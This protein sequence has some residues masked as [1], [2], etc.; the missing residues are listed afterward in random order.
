MYNS[1]HLFVNI[2]VMSF[3]MLETSIKCPCLRL[4]RSKYLMQK[5]TY[6]NNTKKAFV[7]P[8]DPKIQALKKKIIYS[9]YLES[10]RLRLGYIRNI[11]IKNTIKFKER[12]KLINEL[13]KPVRSIFVDQFCNDLKSKPPDEENTNLEENLMID[14][15]YSIVDK[16]NTVDL[17]D[18][19]EEKVAEEAVLLNTD[20]KDLYEKYL[21]AKDSGIAKN[22][23]FSKFTDSHESCLQ[24]RDD[25]ICNRN[26]STDISGIPYNW[27]VDYEQFN[28]EVLYEIKDIFGSAVSDSKISSVPCGGC[29]AKLHCKDKAL[30]GFLASEIFVDKT[31]TQL[32][33]MLC[34][35]CHFIKFYNTALDVK[36]S[37][38]DYPEVLKVI[39]TEKAAIVLMVDLTD[40]PASIW[41]DI[42]S[43]LHP[44]TKIFVVGNKIDLLPCD[45]KQ[46]FNNLKMSL[47]QAV[48][49]Y[50]E[51]KEKNIADINLISCKTK[52]GIEQLITSLQNKWI[53]K[54]NVYLVG[55][56]N[57][58]KSSLFNSLLQSDYCKTQAADIIQQATSS[59]WPGTTLHLL[60]FPILNPLR[61]RKFERTRRL[62]AEQQAVHA[63]KAYRDQQYRMTKNPEYGTLQ[64]HLGK[65]FEE[66]EKYKYHVR[67]IGL[68]DDHPEYNLGRWCYDTPGTVQREQI[69]DLLTTEELFL[70]LPDQVILP[71]SFVV[72]P[73]ETLFIA[74]LGRLD[75]VEGNRFIRVTVFASKKLPVLM[76]HMQDADHIYDTLLESEALVVPVNDNKRLQVWPGL[77][78]K[79]L[80]IEG[81]HEKTSAA[82]IV[83]SNA[84]W[85]SITP[86][87]EEKIRLRAF[88]PEGRGIYVRVPAL[89]KNS[90]NL[91]GSRIRYSP[92]YRKGK[93]IYVTS[94]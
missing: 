30:P 37:I 17:S 54:G 38:D 56:T 90:I 86:M 92:A 34:Q 81:I 44:F 12:V 94:K 88:T 61:W 74:G 83:F 70:T 39:K 65:T 21:E 10:K 59:P 84:G 20:Y 25:K 8:I 43:V 41:P 89:L 32:R 66:N 62:K 33:S 55:C 80:S 1:S 77:K 2:G 48:L 72:C 68:R 29:G 42:A 85:I 16:F 18:K 87:Q 3:T 15:P 53:N 5:L 76:C 14:L 91:R 73:N 82:D 24:F 75:Y 52:Y 45:S 51:I 49:D 67:E 23:T 35:R 31:N 11:M 58:G 57:V 93:S 22:I 47:K 60:K 28:D 79:D 26:S 71:R 6:S 27:M 4:Y 46:F 78:S 13:N 64:G 36:V 7:K 63:E 69:L 9:E 19:I 50:T 40:F